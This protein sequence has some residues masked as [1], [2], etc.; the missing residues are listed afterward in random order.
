MIG[1]LQYISIGETPQ[2]HLENIQSICETGCE[3]VQLRLKDR[4]ENTVLDTAIQAKKICDLYGA[5]LIINDFPQIAKRIDA[6]GVHLGKN[7][8]KPS[9]ARVLLGEKIIIGGTANTFEDIKELHTEGVDYIGLG[10]FRFT[11]TQKNLS[12]VLGLEGYRKIVGRCIEEGIEIPII[13]IGGIKHDDIS[14]LLETRVYG[15]AMASGM[16][17]YF[18]SRLK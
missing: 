2:K 13:A 6:S 15:V 10:P 12:T 8:M 14:E 7:D 11:E 16:E 17:E 4:D 5:D 1:K 3:W 9:V 18:Q